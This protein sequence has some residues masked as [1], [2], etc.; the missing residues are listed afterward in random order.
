VPIV[1]LIFLVQVFISPENEKLHAELVK[2]KIL[3]FSCLSNYTILCIFE[4]HAETK[5]HLF[6][7]IYFSK[8]CSFLVLA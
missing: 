3:Y 2:G 5:T 8:L 6:I 7:Y 1:I 4:K